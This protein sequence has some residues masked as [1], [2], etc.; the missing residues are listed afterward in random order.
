M[1]QLVRGVPCQ[2]FAELCQ[3]RRRI[4]FAQVGGSEEIPELQVIGSRYGS[5]PQRRE[6]RVKRLCFNLQAAQRNQDRGAFWM[7]PPRTQES[8]SR[9]FV[10]MH[11]PICI[12]ES[13]FG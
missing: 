8:G 9:F 3:R 1:R 10:V 6:R 13:K 5:G 7:L 2:R 12:G 4:S 11:S